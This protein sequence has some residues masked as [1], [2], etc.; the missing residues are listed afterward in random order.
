MKLAMKVMNRE[1]K[2]PP[3]AFLDPQIDEELS[4][5]MVKMK[6]TLLNI[7][8]PTQHA[9]EFHHLE[10]LEANSV[11]FRRQCRALIKMHKPSI[12]VL[13][14]TKMKDHTKITFELGYDSFI[15]AAAKDLS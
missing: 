10:C 7:P 4:S 1:G 8:P 6:E 3:R 5:K 9:N 11:S 15:Q 12:M 13:L 14:A 2:T